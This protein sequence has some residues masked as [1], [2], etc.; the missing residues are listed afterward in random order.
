[1]EGGMMEVVVTELTD[2]LQA[3]YQLMVR[4]KRLDCFQEAGAVLPL[5]LE[6]LLADDG[7]PMKSHAA[8]WTRVFKASRDIKGFVEVLKAETVPGKRIKVHRKLLDRTRSMLTASRKSI[9][10]S[11]VY[12]G[13]KVRSEQV[14]EM[15]SALCDLISNGM[16]LAPNE[17][18]EMGSLAEMLENA[19]NRLRELNPDLLYDAG[20]VTQP[21]T[22]DDGNDYWDP[23]GPGGGEGGG[24]G[25][26]G[27]AAGGGS[28][29]SGGGGNWDYF[30]QLDHDLSQFMND[31]SGRTPSVPSVSV[32]R[33]ETQS[34]TGTTQHEGAPDHSVNNLAAT[35]SASSIGYSSSIGYPQSTA[36]PSSKVND[37]ATG[38][39]KLAE[40]ELGTSRGA[41]SSSQSSSILDNY[42]RSGSHQ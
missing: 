10:P 40:L 11:L 9:S 31:Y 25:N 3:Q 16:S 24:G 12:T 29:G 2:A 32:H 42:S 8:E 38:N 17:T 7:E 20:D 34:G 39:T 5:L 22:P 33:S 37:V 26:G 41:L 28:G 15:T 35:L 13:I 23:K 14:D 18:A 30:D 36:P 21:G 4:R 6:G 19:A 1:M 27:G